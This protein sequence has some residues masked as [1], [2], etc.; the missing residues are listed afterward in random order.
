MFGTL[1]CHPP[2]IRRHLEGPLGRERSAYLERLAEWGYRRSTLL[3]RAAYVS[4]V[5]RELVKW[6]PGHR[7]TQAEV[8]AMAS[9][10]ARERPRA[11]SPTLPKRY[12]RLEATEFLRFL[13]R[14]SPKP[15]PPPGRFDQQLEE[16]VAAQRNER[17]LAPETCRGRRWQIK[18]FLTCLEDQDIDLGDVEP[19][20]VDAYFGYMSQRWSRRSL[21]TTATSLRAWFRYAEARGWVRP[22]LADVVVAPR[23]YRDEGLPL[24][25]TWEQVQQLLAG[26]E[27]DRPKELRDR[28]ILLLLFVYGL[29]SDE[30]RRLTVD[31]ID[32]EQECIRL[33]RAKSF[34][35]ETFPIEPTVGNALARYLREGRPRSDSRVVFLTVRAPFRPLSSGGLYHVVQERLDRLGPPGKGRGPHGLRHACARHLVESGHSLKVV[36]DH[37]GHR[38]PSSTRIYAK[39]DLTSLRRVAFDDLGGLT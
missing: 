20:D 6:P 8:D 2:A 15:D 26:A 34:R 38:S 10:W 3:R 19:A 28:A 7:F 30:V 39:V 11:T 21:H 37:L 5:A 29:R 27:G 32:W 31:D 12:F 16:F 22:A 17:G 18:Q 14:L 33:R 24:G 13:D 4:C 25:P 36:G 35:L 9:A 23:V 1:F